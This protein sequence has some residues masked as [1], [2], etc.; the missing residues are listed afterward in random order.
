M[1]Y[2]A[3]N[4]ARGLLGWCGCHVQT[5]PSSRTPAVGFILFCRLDVVDFNMAHYTWIDYIM[6]LAAVS[7]NKMC[8]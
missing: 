4:T 6:G 5:F 2:K 1:A 8:F 3:G 7:I